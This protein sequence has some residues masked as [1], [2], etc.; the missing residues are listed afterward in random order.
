MVP[1]SLAAFLR[2]AQLGGFLF[3]QV[4]G[5]VTESGH[6]R[7]GVALADAACVLGED[8]IE[9]PMRTG[10]SHSNTSFIRRI[11]RTAESC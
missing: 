11:T 9:A 10:V 2:Q 3:G 4:H 5:Q 8:H 6:D 7:R 1:G